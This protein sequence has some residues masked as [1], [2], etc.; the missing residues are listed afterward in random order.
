MCSMEQ[1]HQGSI[2]MRQLL[3]HRYASLIETISKL[4]EITEQQKELITTKILTL[5]WINQALE[6]PNSDM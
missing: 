5:D 6:S 3:F 1:Y 2:F 4:Y